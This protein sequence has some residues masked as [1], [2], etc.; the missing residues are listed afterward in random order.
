MGHQ[1]CAEL[2]H[3]EAPERAGDASPAAAEYAPAEYAP[4]EHVSADYG[5]ADYGS[6]DYGSADYGFID[7]D[8][9]RMFLVACLQAS[10]SVE[11][12]SSYLGLDQ[13]TVREE[14]KQGIEAW[15]AR[16]RHANEVRTR[17]Q[18]RLAASRD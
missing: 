12:M 9:L 16:R 17:P 10:V 1:N 15:N 18:L 6:A 13:E 4:A 7:C 3:I 14:L 11:T 2:L 5:S 8:E